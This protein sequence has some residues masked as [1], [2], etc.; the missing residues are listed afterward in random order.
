[1][2]LVSDGSPYDMLVSASNNNKNK[3]L[4]DCICVK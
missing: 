4:P 1:M 2:L 3:K